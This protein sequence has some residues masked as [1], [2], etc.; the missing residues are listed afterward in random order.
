MFNGDDE[1]LSSEFVQVSDDADRCGS[2]RI[3]MHVF[4][5]NKELATPGA[6]DKFIRNSMLIA[7]RE[8]NF[9]PW[10]REKFKKNPKIDQMIQRSS[11]NDAQ[12]YDFMEDS[13]VAN[14]EE[15]SYVVTT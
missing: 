5:C 13:S 15:V 12:S 6:I 1:A 10:I 7:R 3:I 8:A 4:T 11:S 2:S 9:V 14:P